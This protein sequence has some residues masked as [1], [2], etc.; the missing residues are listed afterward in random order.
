MDDLPETPPPSGAGPADVAIWGRLPP[1]IGGMNVHVERLAGRLR[2]AG[3]TFQMYS[4]I[5][6]TPPHPWVKEV[7]NRR[8]RWVLGMLF[9]RCERLHYVLGGRPVTRF[10]AGLVGLLRRRKIVFRVGGVRL[11]NLPGL[12]G[13]WYCRWMHRFGLRRADAVI[14]VSEELCDLARRYGARPERVHRIPGFIRASAQEGSPPPEVEAFAR[15]RSPVLIGSG[16]LST[17]LYGSCYAPGMYLD[18]MERLVRDR[19]HA[20]LVFYAYEA[21]PIG[22]A[23]YRVFQAELEKRNLVD[24]ILL[25]RST[26]EFWP[27][28]KVADVMLRAT[29]KDGDSNAVR[30]AVS[31]GVPVIASDCAVRPESVVPFRTDDPQDFYET[32]SRVLDD[33]TTYRRRA[34]RADMGDYGGA[35]VD[36]V[37]R[38]LNEE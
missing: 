23:P 1:P 35:V 21:Q 2:E 5:R 33:L 24:R 25:Y 6:P 34:E 36:L 18:L 7:S 22:E 26:G 31:L 8:L 37:T 3:I 14:G 15:E 10:V 38:L 11:T 19:P 29:R 32:V 16:E 30:E 20:G 17:D 9:G 4:I 13:P 28:L 27:A 12:T